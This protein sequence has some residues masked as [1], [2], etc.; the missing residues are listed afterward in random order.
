MEFFINK[1]R[2]KTINKIQEC[3]DNK[4]LVLINSSQIEICNSCGQLTNTFKDQIDNTV[5]YEYYK[6]NE[7]F[8]S[9]IETRNPKLRKM[10]IW[11]SH[12]HTEV[13]YKDRKA[14]LS[15]IVK[16]IY[17]HKT[18][19][20]TSLLNEYHTYYTD[21]KSI[22]ELIKIIKDSKLKFNF[23]DSTYDTLA[24]FVRKNK[25]AIINNNRNRS[26]GIDLSMFYFIIKNYYYFYNSYENIIELINY[27]NIS[28]T[29]Y[30]NFIK[31]YILNS[32]N[33]TNEDLIYL[34]N[35]LIQITNFMNDIVDFDITLF[36]DEFNKRKINNTKI[37]EKI[38]I[39]IILVNI[40]P[41]FKDKILKYLKVSNNIFNKYS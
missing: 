29:K 9:Y 28:I 7:F 2:N 34:P 37:Q 10:H 41:D 31:K 19:F 24:K 8:K 30:N 12:N 36:I 20:L 38:L 15:K 14:M 23:K 4:Q 22:S 16:K 18:I 32:N 11:L 27:L 3:C 35:K 39:S 1:Y 17:K 40:Y 5:N 33:Y 26:S 21:K 13:I 6:H 25:L